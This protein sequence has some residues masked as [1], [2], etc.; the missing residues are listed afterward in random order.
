[1]FTYMSIVA[2]IAL[3]MTVLALIQK[4]GENKQN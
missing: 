3:T 1:M 4:I 2:I